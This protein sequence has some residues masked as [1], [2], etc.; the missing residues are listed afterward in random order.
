[1]VDFVECFLRRFHVPRRPSRAGHLEE[2]M[3]VQYMHKLNHTQFMYVIHAQTKSYR[4]RSA[5]HS[6]RDYM[7]ESGPDGPDF[8]ERL[9][10]LGPL[11]FFAPLKWCNFWPLGGVAIYMS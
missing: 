8:G 11:D 3:I 6:V 2:Y 9:S 1:M 7:S 5:S 10:L 4:M